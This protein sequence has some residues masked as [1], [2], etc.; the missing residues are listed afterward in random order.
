MPSLSLHQYQVRPA[1]SSLPVIRPVCSVPFAAATKRNDEANQEAII[2]GSDKTEQ[3]LLSLNHD[4]NN[5]DDV[6]LELLSQLIPKR[7]TEF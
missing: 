4:F 3:I 5:D 2:Q 1:I 7:K 6:L